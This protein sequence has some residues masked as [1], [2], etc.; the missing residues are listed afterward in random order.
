M[1]K[2]KKKRRDVS[3]P[4]GALGELCLSHSQSSAWGA[5]ISFVLY[6]LFS[7]SDWRD[8]HRMKG[9]SLSAH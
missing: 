2:K 6:V 5:N 3:A 4:R 8:G 7:F 9:S 1:I